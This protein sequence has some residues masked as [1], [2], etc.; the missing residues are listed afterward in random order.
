MHFG[1]GTQ[2][3]AASGFFS[4]LPAIYGPVSPW[5]VIEWDK[6]EYLDPSQMSL[7]GAT[8]Y[9]PLLGNAAYSWATPD[10]ELSLSIYGNGTTSPWVYDLRSSGGLFTA[11]GGSNVFL[12]D[13][14]IAPNATFDDQITFQLTAKISQAI[15][16]YD[17]AAASTDGV[18]LAQAFTGFTLWFNEPGTAAFDSTLPSFNV[19]MQIPITGSNNDAAA[20]DYRSATAL[21]G[22]NGLTLVYGHVLPND[23]TL[24]FVASSGSPTTLTYNLDA[25]LADLIAQPWP[26][27]NAS[28]TTSWVWLPSAVNNL[29]DWSLTSTYVG[30]ETE[31]ADG[32]PG[33]NQTPQGTAAIGLQISDLQVSRDTSTP[34]TAAAFDS[35]PRDGGLNTTLIGSYSA[36]Q[37]SQLTPALTPIVA[38]PAAVALGG[39]RPGAVPGISLSETGNVPGETFAVTAADTAGL[40]STSTAGG[41]VLSGAGTASLT[42][43]GSLAAVNAALAGLT[44]TEPGAGADRITLTAVDSL[45]N[46]ATQAAIA[47]TAHASPVLAAPASLTLGIGRPASLGGVA[48]AE[49]GATSGETFS[50]KLQDAHGFLS[51]GTAG[52]ATIAGA[53]TATL[54][55]SGSLSA[56]DAALATLRVTDATAGVDKIAVTASDS[57]GG[58][59]NAA[60]IIV[61]ANG[62]PT[63]KAPAQAT[64]S[65]TAATA[66]TGA[67]VSETGLTAGEP[68]AATVSDLH[69]LLSANAAAGAAISGSGSMALKLAGSLAQVNAALATLRDTD[70]VAGADTLTVSASD[71]F[72]NA[73]SATVAISANGR[74][75]LA[76]PAGVVATLDQA[77]VLTTAQAPFIVTVAPASGGLIASPAPVANFAAGDEIDFTDLVPGGGITYAQTTPAVGT[78]TIGGES[79]T[80]AGHFTASLFQLTGDG[81]G[82][83]L[84]RYT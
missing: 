31:N 52:G 15:V 3:N 34:V 73:A 74:A 56:V 7:N 82:G 44:D 47:V 35:Q 55:I 36:W 23:T 25:Y 10:G 13:A 4:S 27:S 17:N 48:L 49:A 18:V 2:V 65:T 64:V 30:L 1:N 70:T 46:A 81:H 21:A 54:S 50:V 58:V 83:T 43:S 20:T 80:L 24:P 19:F 37:Q 66:I 42:V 72:G 53:N 32:R 33:A 41:A 84:V 63:I 79:V 16:S 77:T 29:A 6:N 59:A 26:V 78:L 62:L 22:V 9:D 51:A 8:T 14:T 38:A 61:V 12:S 28:G 75:A 11:G 76:A 39:G 69:G 67:G 60:A 40:L 5:S 68:F 71:G 57:L 45:G